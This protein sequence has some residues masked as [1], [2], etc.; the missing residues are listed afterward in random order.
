MFMGVGLDLW[1]KRH[2]CHNPQTGAV[3]LVLGF[4]VTTAPI[5]SSG[6]INVYLAVSYTFMEFK[7]F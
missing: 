3:K 7:L 5:L 1:N 2:L 6:G 4:L